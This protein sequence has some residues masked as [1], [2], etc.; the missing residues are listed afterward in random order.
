MAIHVATMPAGRG[1]WLAA[2]LVVHNVFDIQVGSDLP[3]SLHLNSNILLWY[4]AVAARCKQLFHGVTDW[5]VRRCDKPGAAVRVLEKHTLRLR[6]ATTCICP[7]LYCNHT[8]TLQYTMDSCAMGGT[9]CFRGPGRQ[10]A[11]AHE[12]A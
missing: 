7:S 5:H 8:L 9:I 12:Q 11:P 3:C 10:R 2:W 6:K 1:R 4:A